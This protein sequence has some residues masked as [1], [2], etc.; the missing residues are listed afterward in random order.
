[1]G[2]PVMGPEDGCWEIFVS[3][4]DPQNLDVNE[5]HSSVL[6]VGLLNYQFWGNQTIQIYGDF[7]GFP[8]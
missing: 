2:F 1:M 8:L 3:H 4:L 7:E 5:S 6:G